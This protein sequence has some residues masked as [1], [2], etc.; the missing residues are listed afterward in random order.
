MALELQPNWPKGFFRKG[1]AL[2]GLKVAWQAEGLQG[3]A[4]PRVP[5][6]SGSAALCSQRY[7]E[8]RDTF[9]NLQGAHADVAVQLEA[10]QM[11]LQV[12]SGLAAASPLLPCAL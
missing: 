10:C 11:L 8:A 3:S 1:K 5:S 6:G 4:Q 12:S 2:W 9:K 7:A